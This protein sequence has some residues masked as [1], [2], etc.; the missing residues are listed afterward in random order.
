MRFAAFSTSYSLKNLFRYRPKVA[1]EF[2]SQ[3]RKLGIMMKHKFPLAFS[4]AALV[5]LAACNA[6]GNHAQGNFNAAG[7][8]LGN[9]DI[10][11]GASDTGHA[12]S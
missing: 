8:A 3:D 11:A 10:G 5:G 1:V 7:Q 12:F 2:R 9:G 4:F 6:H